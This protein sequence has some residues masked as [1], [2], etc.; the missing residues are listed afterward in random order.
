MGEKEKIPSFSFP[1]R[2]HT[3]T[4]FRIQTFPSSLSIQIFFLFWILLQNQIRMLLFWQFI[5]IKSMLFIT[6]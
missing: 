1:F 4:L 2:V 3:H 6:N 5:Y